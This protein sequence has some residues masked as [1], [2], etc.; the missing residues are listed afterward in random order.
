MINLYRSIKSNPEDFKQLN[1]RNML[2]T[3]IDFPQVGNKGRAYMEYN[4][5]VYVVSGKGDFNRNNKSWQLE[6]GTCAFIKKGVTI[7]I[8]EADSKWEMM[9]FFMPD[10]FLKRII[11]DNRRNLP[12]GYLPAADTDQLLP[13]DLGESGKSLFESMHSYLTQSPPAPQHILELKFKELVLSLLAKKENSRLLSF[14]N[15]LNHNEVPSVEYIML[16]NY[17]FNLS[18]ADFANL[19]YRGLEAF[20]NE[21]KKTFNDT[22]AKWLI[23]KRLDLAEE[24]LQNT[25]LSI[26]ELTLSCGFENQTHFNKIFKDRTGS[27]PK[28]YRAMQQVVASTEGQR[29]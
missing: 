13:L 22:P 16:N 17:T 25:S 5:I 26:E 6:A 18:L 15:S 9:I 4:A 14:L 7:S 20:K 3:Y 23:R 28:Q 19:S 2:F 29:I 1:C 24:L 12:M 10:E 8:K 21:F 11:N 27:S